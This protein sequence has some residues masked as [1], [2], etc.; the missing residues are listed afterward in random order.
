MSVH[1][2]IHSDQLG[3]KAYYLHQLAEARLPVPAFISISNQELETLFGTQSYGDLFE[4]IEKRIE[5]Y[6]PLDLEGALKIFGQIENLVKDASPDQRVLKEIKR[7]CVQQFGE[8]YI[9]SVRSSAIGEDGTKRSFAGIHRTVLYVDDGGLEAAIKAS[10]TSA[11]SPATLNYRV[12]ANLPITRIKYALVIQQM[13]HAS[14]SGVAFSMDVSGNLADS[15]INSCYGIGEGLVSGSLDADTYWISRSNGSISSKLATKSNRINWYAK[16][17]L[18]TELVEHELQK[19]SSLSE[20]EIRQ[21]QK[22]LMTAEKMLG[23]P[24]DIE[25]VIDGDHQLHLLQMRPISTINTRNLAILDNTNIIESYPGISLPLSFS[26]AT[27]AYEHIFRNCAQIF[28]VKDEALEGDKVYQNL[29][30]HCYG[31]IYYRLDNWYKMTARVYKSKRALKAWEAAVGLPDSRADEFSFSLLGKLK[32]ASVVAGFVF[33]YRRNNRRF[34]REFDL[35]YK[36]FRSLAQEG[37]AGQEL[38]QNFIVHIDRALNLWPYTIVNDFLAFKTYGWL[39]SLVRALGISEDPD[40]A[41]GLVSGYGKVHS[42]EAVLQLLSLKD[43]VLDNPKLIVLFEQA[44]TDIWR[45][46]QVDDELNSFYEEVLVYLACYGDRTM[47]ELKLETISPAMQP[48]LLIDLLK[49]QLQSPVF[50]KDLENRQNLVR[51]QALEILDKGYPWFHPARWLVNMVRKIA[52]FG[53]MSRE[54]MRFCRTRM[55]AASRMIFL[56]LATEMV[57]SGAL[58]NERDIFYLDMANIRSYYE[59]NTH[60]FLEIVVE[61]KNAYARYSELKLPDRIMFEKGSFPSFDHRKKDGV[62]EDREKGLFQGTAV[63]R[64]IVEGEALVITE[65]VLTA[66]V[67]G[68]ILISRMTDPGWVFLMSQAVALVTEKGSILS[69]TAIVG[70]ELGLPVV[71]GVSDATVRIKT[72][73]RIRVDGSKGTVVRI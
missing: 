52:A 57:R 4:E 51:T 38:W 22:L 6:N 53:V 39:Q 24:A 59:G 14:R 1:Q 41:N 50:R 68:K 7:K 33:N 16:K 34:F 45:Q 19:A 64:G 25:F 15:V 69:H 66:D 17:G 44:S 67:R 36:A 47:A 20:K 72:G 49:S 9:V 10:L 28:R 70:R 26:F 35:V 8:G 48:E 55:Y 71:V 31:R 2:K 18:V 58:L 54:N 29:I 5:E 46:L 61:R 40:F 12:E 42:E 73:E 23:R 13:I 43:Q 30:A 37:I 3:G 60:S 27:E 32:M 65:P 11:W 21:V 63:S 62:D 56:K